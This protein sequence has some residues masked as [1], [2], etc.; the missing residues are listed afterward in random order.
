MGAEMK[1]GIVPALFLVTFFV[2]LFVMGSDKKKD[3]KKEEKT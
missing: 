1:R 2:S 3:G